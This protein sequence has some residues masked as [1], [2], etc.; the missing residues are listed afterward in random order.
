MSATPIKPGRP[1]R[2]L[3]RLRQPPHGV[4]PDV[5]VTLYHDGRVE[6]RERWNRGLPVVI[7]LGRAMNRAILA[8]LGFED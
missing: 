5:F 8:G 7:D 4:R 3:V 6:I 2:R 1:V